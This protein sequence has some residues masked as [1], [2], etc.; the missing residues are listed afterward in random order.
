MGAVARPR[1]STADDWQSY[2]HVLV[3]RLTF[4]VVLGIAL[5]VGAGDGL[6]G[7]IRLE[8]QIAN[9]VLARPSRVS[10]AAV[11]EHQVVVRLQVF[12]IYSEDALQHG[13]SIRIL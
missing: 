2:R 8:T 10:Q 6:C 3:N 11:A 5:P 12:G 9:L 13:H 7:L 1:M 4:I